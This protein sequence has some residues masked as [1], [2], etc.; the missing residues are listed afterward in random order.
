[1][2]VPRIFITRT[3]KRWKR[4][5][6]LQSGALY[7]A[8]SEMT[9]GLVDADLGGNVFKKRIALPGRGKRGSVRTIVA[10]NFGKRWF[11]LY[12]FNKNERSDI[13]KKEL[14]ILREVASD[15]LA[16]NDRQIQI[17]VSTREI[18][19]ISNDSEKD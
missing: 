11:F 19:E 5:T 10:T 17:A 18:E 3:F 14:K 16:L 15:L 2:S 12:G 13:G 8:V 9:Q 1:M 4:R 6:G 7:L